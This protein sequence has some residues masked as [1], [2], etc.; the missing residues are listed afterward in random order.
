M[1]QP[2]ANA[3]VAIT[4]HANNA[5][6]FFIFLGLVFYSYQK[7][8]II[9]QLL[10]AGGERASPVSCRFAQ[11]PETLCN[12]YNRACTVS[13]IPLFKVSVI[14]TDRVTS[15]SK[16]INSH[17][18]IGRETEIGV[19]LTRLRNL[20]AAD[21]ETL[22]Q[23]VAQVTLRDFTHESDVHGVTRVQ[24]EETFAWVNYVISVF[25]FFEVCVVRVNGKTGITE[26]INS[27]CTRVCAK[28]VCNLVFT[29][30]K[31]IGNDRETGRNALIYIS[32]RVD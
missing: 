29:I 3:E 21:R 11:H 27:Q 2:S 24:N 8:I 30:V 19:Q 23:S 20:R 32:Y 7:S 16:L 12:P 31:R 15:C 17:T 14:S 10:F 22:W 26:A 18:L 13:S 9:Y 28:N 6:N 25:P 4:V 1:L 5:T